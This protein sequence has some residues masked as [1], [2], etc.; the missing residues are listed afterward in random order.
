MKNKKILLLLVVL[1][2][3]VV[4]VVVF[5]ISRPQPEELLPQ[6]FAELP[7]KPKLIAEFHHGATLDS[8]GIAPGAPEGFSVADARPIYSVAFSPVDASLVASINGGGSINLW[9]INNTKKPIRTLKHPGIFQNIS[10]SPTGELLA[11]AGSGKLIFWDVPSGKK[12]S[13][14][15]NASIQFA[16][17]P[18]GKQLA[19]LRSKEKG[20]HEVFVKIWDIQNPKNI[21]EIASLYKSPE[22]IGY[23]CAVDIS[24]D[25]KWIAVGD[26]Y[27]TI[28]VWNLPSQQLV[29]SIETPLYSM[30]YVKFSPNNKCM[31][32]GGREMGMYKSLRMNGYIMWEL[33]SWQ[34]KGTVLRGF[35]ENLVFSPDGRMCV[36]SNDYYR[37]GRGVE[38]WSTANGEPIA[39]LQIEAMDVSFS[40]DGKL[41]TTG[42]KD[43]IVQV[44]ELTQSQLD[45]DKIRN[46]VVRLIYYLPKDKEPAPNITQKIEKTIREVQK[47]YADEMERHGFGRKTFTFETD[48]NGK[49]KIYRMTENQAERHDLQLNDNWLIFVDKNND[50]QS[51]LTDNLT[52]RIKSAL[53]ERSIHHYNENFVYPTRK[54]NMAN[55]KIW[56]GFIEGSV[57]DGEIVSATKKDFDWKITAYTLKHSFGIIHQNHRSLE[58]ERNGVKRLFKRINRMMPW[59][60][61]WVKLS[62]CEAEWLDKSRFFNP[63]HTYFDKRPEIEISELKIATDSLHF[64]FNAADEDGI[65]QLLL[66]VPKDIDNLYRINKLHGCQTLNGQKK[67]TVE[68]EVAN[69]NIKKGEIRMIDMHGNIASREF[70][71]EEK[72]DEK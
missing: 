38:I 52:K 47:H 53:T 23:A 44:W 72:T 51:V 40:Q 71:I 30:D 68:F 31:V 28:N 65:H 57:G 21:K 25:G 70:W 22:V 26:V 39:S 4:G 27:G 33:P 63:I 64:Q 6:T 1:I 36:G 66:F 14:L 24:S 67:G 69:S 55:G 35:D 20:I 13:T 60:K 59:G 10:F 15:E 61:G 2:I 37:F 5:F 34:R 32:A 19:T 7:E 16:F 17:S 9:N 43:G 50:L 46:D 8:D 11:S 29:K 12:V 58:I 56:M 18:D 3:A 42:N 48:E 45:I 62:K 49:A 41:L 54:M